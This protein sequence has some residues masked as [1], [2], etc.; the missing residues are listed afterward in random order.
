MPVL[1]IRE[2]VAQ[3]AD[4]QR[5]DGPFELETDHVLQIHVDGQVWTKA[6]S[7]IAYRGAI[8]FEREGLLERGVGQLLK[9]AISLLS[10]FLSSV[11]LISIWPT[12]K[13]PHL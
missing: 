6:G 3:T 10:I 1:S 11:E 8:S 5:N 13:E 7:M 12:L 4:V 9:K 2:F